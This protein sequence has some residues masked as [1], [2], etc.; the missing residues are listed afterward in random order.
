MAQT[1]NVVQLKQQMLQGFN[2]YIEDAESAMERTSASAAAFLWCD[3]S[4]GIA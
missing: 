4:S 1:A 3:S 2:V